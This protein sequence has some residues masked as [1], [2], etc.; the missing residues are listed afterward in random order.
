VCKCDAQGCLGK[1]RSRTSS[2][3]SATS[4]SATRILSFAARRVGGPLVGVAK[5]SPLHLNAPAGEA[6][7]N[8]RTPEA[9]EGAK[10][11]NRGNIGSRYV[12]VLL[13]G[14][15]SADP[16]LAADLSHQ[17]RGVDCRAATNARARGER[18]PWSP[19][20]LTSHAPHPACRRPRQWQRW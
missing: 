20:L 6:L 10:Q 4:L 16:P 13:C 18:L 3:S 19:M 12:E 9:L 15:A 7:V 11:R 17:S 14:R 2:S 1:P 5:S 8:V